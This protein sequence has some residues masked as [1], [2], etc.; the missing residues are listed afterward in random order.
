[1]SEQVDI[2][3]HISNSA[4][5]QLPGRKFPGIVIQGDT[6]SNLFEGARCLLA[7]HRQLQDEEQYYETLDIA[8]ALQAQLLHYEQTLAEHGFRLPYT[9]PI[10]QRLVINDFDT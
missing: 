8:E 1:M 5:V 9:I 7:Q 4:I 2:L 3:S 6:L 10:S